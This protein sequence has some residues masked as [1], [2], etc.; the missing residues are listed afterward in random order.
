MLAQL[1]K[2]IS[3]LSFYKKNTSAPSTY[4]DLK[5]LGD[6]NSTLFLKSRLPGFVFG[7][8]RNVAA[9]RFKID[10]PLRTIKLSLIAE[11][12]EVLHFNH[13]A[14]WARDK[15]GELY[16]IDSGYQCSMSSVSNVLPDPEQ[17]ML[18]S[19]GNSVSVHSKRELK[20]WWQVQFETTHD[21]AFIELHNRKDEWG[22]RTISLVVSGWDE[23]GAKTY[24]GG[25]VIKAGASKSFYETALPLLEQCH[26]YL[27]KH[28][29]ASQ[30]KKL[31][32]QFVAWVTANQ[33]SEDHRYKLLDLLRDTQIKI[34]RNTPDISGTEANSHRFNVPVGTT[35]LRII[36]YRRKMP[37]PVSLCISVDGEELTL[38]EATDNRYTE[39]HYKDVEQ[40][41]TLQHPH[42]FYLDAPKLAKGGEVS[43]WYA[44]S[45][46]GDAFVQRNIQTSKDGNEW[47]TIET[48]IDNLAA[49]LALISA[50]EW[51]LGETWNQSFANQL[52]HFLATFRMSQARTVKPLLRA[53]RQLL[54]SFYTGV[55][56]G[57]GTSQFLHP[58]VYTRHGLTIPFEYI[59]SDFLAN[60]MKRFTD[61]LDAKL[62]LKAFPCYGTLLG[63][64]RDGDFLP[65]DDDI[66]LAVVVDLPKET[67]Y[68]DAT[69]QW[70]AKLGE[71]GLLCRPPT[72]SSLNLHCYFED[73][74]MDLFFIY[75]IPEKSDTVW[76]HMEGYQAREV[77]RSLLEPQ[78]TLH[79]CG[80]EFYAPAKI[81]AFLKERY[82]YGWFEPDP[83]F[84]L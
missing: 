56:E 42:V 53:N 18:G 75:R 44:G 48:T 17:A 37:R 21:V 25:W 72:P 58:V 70:A 78:S 60:R 24:Q 10:L 13:I 41:W 55:K 62:G 43:F 84:E 69:K 80:Y 68:L 67:S 64:Y 8:F 49:R 3:T 51:L 73:F 34:Q 52:G 16:R 40:V 14:I 66:D 9:K 65:H 79:F 33:T 27:C 59:D 20:P 1:K 77:E 74:D 83:T 5:E 2:G 81:E 30:A 35:Q 50:Q 4:H 32:G 19:S 39:Q 71:H 46:S 12:K 11:Y 63:I 31:E 54:S 7:S 26:D 76:T 29:M 6:V 47:L 22:S 61:F 38:L 28:G 36:G 15:Q 82:G 23:N 57:G 45:Y